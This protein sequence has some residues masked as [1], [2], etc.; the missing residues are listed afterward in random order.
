[1]SSSR[2]TLLSMA[3][4]PAAGLFLRLR[5]VW[6]Y[7]WR[8]MGQVLRWWVR[9]RETTN[10]T[11][12][13]TPLSRLQLAALA[14]QVT[15]A[16]PERV[17]ELFDELEQD[18]AL[19]AHIV[20]LASAPERRHKSDPQ[21]PYGRRLVW[22]ALVRLLRPQQVVETGVEKGLGSVVICA[23]LL[24]N[25][26]EGHPG[27][28][29]GTDINP[30]AGYLLAGPYAEVGRIAYGDSL[31]SLEQLTGAVDLFIN[32]SDH[33]ADY[34]ANEYRCIAPRLS[35][36]AVVVGD[37]AHATDRLYQFARSTGRRYLYTNEVAEGHWFPGAG[38]G[39]AW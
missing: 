10:L 37:N 8:Y 14:A 36:Q 29:I 12:P 7:L 26:A 38:V 27:Q 9:A 3:L 1:M 11:Y 24:R 28:Y 23:A 5:V 13:I 32:D 39:V 35:P 18:G 20:Q 30:R 16:T 15:G 31:A 19:R 6:P 33:S 17:L 34:E 2:P 25:R 4:A 22:Y 21:M